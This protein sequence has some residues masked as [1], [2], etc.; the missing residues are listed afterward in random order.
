MANAKPRLSVP[1]TARK[2]EVITIKT[3]ITH[4]M[5]TGLRKDKAGKKIPRQI[6]NKFVVT[7]NGKEVFSADMHPAVAANP[8]IAFY[9]KATESG[10]LDFSW[11]E[12]GG[13]VIKDSKKISVS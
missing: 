10:A 1:K 9:V 7:Y 8:Y 11:T 2:G 13:Q 4:K 3:L 5:E 6:I 12:D